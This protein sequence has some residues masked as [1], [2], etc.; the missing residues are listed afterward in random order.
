MSYNNFKMV[1][2]LLVNKIQILPVRT[3]LTNGFNLVRD[4]KIV[5]ALTADKIIRPVLENVGVSKT[6]IKD[7]KSEFLVKTIFSII[8]LSRFW[9]LIIK[10]LLWLPKLILSLFL[11]S[12][13]N[14]DVSSILGWL[15]WGTRGL[16]DLILIIITTIWK[17]LKLTWESGEIKEY[18]LSNSFTTEN[19]Y[20][21]N[22]SLVEVEKTLE[23]KT[24]DLKSKNYNKIWTILSFMALTW[25]VKYLSSTEVVTE[26][27]ENHTWINTVVSGFNHIHSLGSEIN[28]T[29]REHIP[30]VSTIEDSISYVGGAV[31]AVGSTT[32]NYT[33]IKPA[34]GIYSITGYCFDSTIKKPYKYIKSLFDNTEM[35]EMSNKL[36]EL[37]TQMEN[38]AKEK[39]KITDE[40]TKLMNNLHDAGEKEKNV[41]NAKIQE[42]S[43]SLQNVESTLEEQK[44]TSTT[45]SRRGSMEFRKPKW[46]GWGSGWSQTNTPIDSTVPSFNTDSIT[47]EVEP[48]NNSP[49]GLSV[50]PESFEYQEE[51]ETTPRSPLINGSDNTNQRSN[52]S[53][54]PTLVTSNIHK[55][56]VND[57]F[58]G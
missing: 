49:G 53:R 44:K 46:T 9:K 36:K 1:W 54:R 33:I 27:L 47:R 14:I 37:Q 26:F 57:N 2:S 23:N 50:V 41:L 19:E 31:F 16:S 43:A 18:I 24:D 12:L 29:F 28:N 35:S 5:R 4:E 25:A 38:T 51:G 6:E 3:L 20:L 7:S 30:F 55:P 40:L 21:K 13:G 45:L 8:T 56:R 10:M 34:K 15:S 32:V 52:D 42:L 11:L 58:S 17:V 48:N 22:Y 39:T